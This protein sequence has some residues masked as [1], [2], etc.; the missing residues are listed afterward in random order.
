MSNTA[1]K[2]RRSNFALLNREVIKPGYCTSCGGCEAVCPVFVI[3]IDQL[4]PKLI[5]GCI[6]CGACVDVCLRYKQRVEQAAVEE[7]SLG[8]IIELYKGRS[9]LEDIKDNSQNGGVV[10]TLLLTAMRKE[11]I[12]GALVTTHISD[13]L[14]PVPM[15]ALNELDIRK[16]SKSKYTLNPVLIKLPAI[17]LSHKEKVACVG[18]PC[19][20][21]TLSN[22][23]EMKNL[24]AD[25]RVDY[26]I[27]L[28]CMSSY[29]PSTFRNIISQNL[30]LDAE[31][32]Y[33]TD[34][35]RGKFFFVGPD[36]TTDIKIKECSEAKAEGCK[37]C[38]D[39]SA[40]FADI[41]VG[42]VGVGDDSNIILIRTEAG[43]A[44][45]DFALKE[46]VLDVEKVEKDKWEESLAAAKKLSTIKK[47]GAKSLP[48]I[49]SP[50]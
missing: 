40:E 44:L 1:T 27:G 28:F 45:F 21:E 48:P 37:Y 17:K 10:T 24:G 12:D 30:G 6:S 31:S 26:K 4:V 36:G 33:K 7:E 8:E 13:L 29:N 5:G 15:L 47:K 16:A 32:L 9:K 19:H 42:N 43:K 46:N 20:T 18:L 2:K 3:S 25:F 23:I 49:E 41:S 50:K 14:G 39:F 38:L 35:A 34:C 22:A 11:K